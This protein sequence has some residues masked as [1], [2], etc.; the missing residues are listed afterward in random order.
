[1]RDAPG[2]L[3][4]I[5]REGPASVRRVSRE[6]PLSLQCRVGLGNCGPRRDFRKNTFQYRPARDAAS[7]ATLFMGRVDYSSCA[8]R[9]HK[10]RAAKPQPKAR[11]P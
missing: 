6:T 5:Y 10:P 9:D 4:V 8:R 7:H 11:Q 1:M 2:S 3:K